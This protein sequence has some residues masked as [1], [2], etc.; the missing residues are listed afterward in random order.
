MSPSA[1]AASVVPSWL[2]RPQ[3]HQRGERRQGTRASRKRPPHSPLPQPRRDTYGDDVPLQAVG[4]VCALDHSAQLGVAHPRLGAGG[5]HGTWMEEEGDPRERRLGLSR[6]R[7]S[8]PITQPCPH[9]LGWRGP[10]QGGPRSSAEVVITA[11]MAT[12]PFRAHITLIRSGPGHS[13]LHRSPSTLHAIS[14]LLPTSQP[15]TPLLPTFPHFPHNHKGPSD[16]SH[17]LEPP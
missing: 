1:N 16:A 9:F 14:S 2:P 4:R 3:G 11:V 13:S 15:P 6:Q 12:R 10:G 8:S 17:G 7:A 5:A